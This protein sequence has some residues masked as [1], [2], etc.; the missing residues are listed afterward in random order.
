MSSKLRA[1]RLAFAPAGR[2]LP[3]RSSVFAGIGSVASRLRTVCEVV[4][5]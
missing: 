3:S 2:A 1:S 5:R 4:F